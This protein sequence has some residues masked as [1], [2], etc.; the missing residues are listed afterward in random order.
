MFRYNFVFHIMESHIHYG[1]RLIQFM[2]ITHL[3]GDSAIKSTAKSII[4]G[5]FHLDAYFIYEIHKVGTFLKYNSI[6]SF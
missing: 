2:D 4:L 3:E 1:A 6:S 5:I